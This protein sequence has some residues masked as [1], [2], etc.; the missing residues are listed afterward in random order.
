MKI[1]LVE[2]FS[3]YHVFLRNGLCALGHHVDIYSQGDMH[4]QTSCTIKRSQKIKL[5]D[6]KD[7]KKTKKLLK[8][9]DV[10][11]FIGVPALRRNIL[12]WLWIWF[13]GKKYRNRFF[14][15]A[16][17]CDYIFWTE[18][19]RRLKLPVYSECQKYDHAYY[20]RRTTLYAKICSF[21]MLQRCYGVISCNEYYEAYKGKVDNLKA[22]AFP[23][24]LNH[25][26]FEKRDFTSKLV[27]FHGVHKGREG[28]KGTHHIS[29]AFELLNKKYPHEV[30]CI[31]KGGMT[32]S[33][34]L[35]TIE[36]ADVIFDQT[37]VV[38]YGMTGLA[39][40]AMGKIVGCNSQ[41]TE[42]LDKWLPDIGAVERPPLI[43][44]SP[45]V[46]HIVQ[47][48]EWL[49]LNRSIL[50]EMAAKGRMYVENFHDAKKVASNF[51]KFWVG[52]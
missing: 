12:L 23:I 35:N 1:L 15:C 27:I 26:K 9:Y 13:Q 45:N 8:K 4:K 30:E 19:R 34:Y 14:M 44:L 37:N 25:Y 17:G 18:G 6:I 40:M 21:V 22:I 38:G 24:D 11:Q 52:K 7:F 41:N 28:F 47:Q 3:N 50:P 2:D 31:V 33:E 32:Y 46:G 5:F 29:K 43:N 36:R 20:S 10:V 49:L 51:L 16:V 48:V 42:L 39:G